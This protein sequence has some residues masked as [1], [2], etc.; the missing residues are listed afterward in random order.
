RGHGEIEMNLVV[1]KWDKPELLIERF[2]R[3]VDGIDLD[4]MNSQPICQPQT[5]LQGIDQQGPAQSGAL[6]TPIN[7][8]PCQQDDRKRLLGELPGRDGRDVLKG[9]RAGGQR[10]VANDAPLARTEGDIGTPQIAFL[11]LAHKAAQEV[12]ERTFPAIEPTAIVRF[13]EL[14]D[15]PVI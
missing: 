6:G 4:G 8:Q 14:L 10:V 12:V 5:S 15:P 9:D 11:V 13:P 7:R 3:Y 1:E 2:R